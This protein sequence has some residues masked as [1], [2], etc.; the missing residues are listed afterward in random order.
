MKKKKT[1]SKKVSVSDI[2]DEMRKELSP[3][4]R[5]VLNWFKQKKN[6]NAI[7]KKRRIL[8]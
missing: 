6:T 5:K 7:L 1:G 2:E 8:V 4:E 3:G